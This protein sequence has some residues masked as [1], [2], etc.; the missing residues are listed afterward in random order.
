MDICRGHRSPLH[1]SHPIYV[2]GAGGIYDGRGLA[3]ALMYGAQAVWVG[4]RFVC[5]EEAGATVAHKEAILNADYHETMRSLI[6]TGRP[7]RIVCNPYAVDWAENRQPLIKKCLKEGRI[8]YTYDLDIFNAKKAKGNGSSEK[9]QM[10]YIQ[11]YNEGVPLLSGQAAGAMHDILP[12]QTIIQNMI[13][14]AIETIQRNHVKIT[15]LSK[16]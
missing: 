14:D 2:V 16:L 10:D 3:M 5:S 7:M 1:P 8:P 12:A 13:K 9:F 11:R 6:Y 4:T 15:T